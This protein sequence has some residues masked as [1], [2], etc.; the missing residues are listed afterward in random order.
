MLNNIKM[1]KTKK[2]RLVRLIR[3]WFIRTIIPLEKDGLWMMLK[4]DKKKFW[5][6]L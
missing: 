4:M 1:M 6:I 3:V 5:E 2:Y